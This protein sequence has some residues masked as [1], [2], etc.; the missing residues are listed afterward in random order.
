ME[1]VIIVCCS[2]FRPEILHRRLHS[3]FK[4]HF[5]NNDFGRQNNVP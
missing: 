4:Y 3:E 2:D 5:L 1:Q